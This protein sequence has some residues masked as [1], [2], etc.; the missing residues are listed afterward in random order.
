MVEH[1]LWVL[2]LLN[3]AWELKRGT[4]LDSDVK[5]PKLEKV[6]QQD[7]FISVCLGNEFRRL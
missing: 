7:S 5:M 1:K 3:V 4:D 2:N 6:N